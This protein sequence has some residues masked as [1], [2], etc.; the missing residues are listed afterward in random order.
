M[1][2]DAA[3]S[4]VIRI[5]NKGYQIR[6][7]SMTGAELRSL[8]STPIH[9]ELDLYHAASVGDILIENEMVYPLKDGMDFF[10]APSY[11]S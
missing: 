11:W 10:T 1:L 9:P 4:V 7:D 5:D 6:S 3:P 8:P 2:T